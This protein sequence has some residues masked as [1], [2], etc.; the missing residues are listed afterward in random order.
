MEHRKNIP[1]II[2]VVII[3]LFLILPIFVIIP[4][5]FNSAD[6]ISFPPKGFSLRWYKAFWGNSQWVSALI[7]SIELAVSVTIITLILGIMAA[8]GLRRVNIKGK[9]IIQEFFMLPLYIP[10]IILAIAIYN[11][12]SNANLTGTFAGLVMAHCVLAIP[13]VFS[14]ISSGLAMIDKNVEDAALNLG[15]SRIQTFFEITLPLLKHSIFSAAIFAFVTS[16]DELVITMFISGVSG[17]TLPVMM[18]DCMRTEFDPTITAISSMIIAI[19]STVMCINNAMS[20]K[21]KK[22][23]L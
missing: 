14:S 8:E 9:E 17:T 1:L 5:S 6:Y 4:L 12:E 2:V 10:V 13:Y 20:V 7:R 22:K 21:R 23:K 15:A 18:W 11:F 16:F 3:L 19:L